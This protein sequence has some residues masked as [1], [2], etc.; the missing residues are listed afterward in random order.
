[1]CD[2]NGGTP[3][4][5]GPETGASEYRPA[6]SE[7]ATRTAVVSPPPGPPPGGGSAGA[8]QWRNLPD[9]ARHG[10][11]IVG[12]VLIVLGALMLVGR[13]APWGYIIR[14][15]PLIIVVGGVVEMFRP[16]SEPVIKRVASGI[17]T[18]VTGSVLLLNSL[19]VVPWSV[20]LNML[21]LWPLL[22]VA[23]GIELLGKGLKLDWVRALSNVL[24]ILGLLYGVFVLGPEWRGGTF[25]FA[26]IS[27]EAVSYSATAPHDPSARTGSAAIHV[28]ALRLT[29]RAGDSLAS[30]KGNA[31]KTGSPDLSHSVV[32]GKAEVEVSDVTNGTVIL[33]YPDRTLSVE[34]DRAVAWDELVLDVGAADADVDLR[35]L[36]VS[37]VYANVGASN[38]RMRI[39]DEADKVRV[40]VSGGATAVTIR[41]PDD[42]SVSLVSQS[43]LSSVSV[44]D[45]FEHVSGLPVLG[46][47]RWSKKGSGGPEIEIELKSGVSSIE[48]LTY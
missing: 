17:G 35:D 12:V 47:G 38:L 11:V 9:G 45:D 31:P 48:I 6:E 39:G 18:V 24:L 1:M 10:G 33:P 32:S 40:D 15:W 2:V 22:L 25:T 21:A 7:T 28:G 26:P 5:G 36:E 3:T 4:A 8:G 23:L 44:P 42:A 46:E 37:S 27:G 41:I 20:W 16:G 14:L 19:G 34:L 13:Y 29:V 30:I 43:G